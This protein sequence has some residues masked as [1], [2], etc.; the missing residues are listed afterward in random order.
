MK[1]SKRLIA[2]DHAL[3]EAKA[4]VREVGGWN[5]GPRVELYQGADTLPGNHYAWCQSFQN[6]MWR[7]ATG[8]KIVGPMIVG[9]EMLAEGTASVGQAVAWARSKGYVVTRP[10]RGDHFAMLLDGDSW[11]DHTG[12]VVR[13]VSLGPLGYLCNTVEGNTGSGSVDEGDGVYLRTRFLSKSRTIFYRVPG[14]VDVITRTPATV[15]RR[16][17]GYWSWLQWRLGEGLW[18]GW[19]PRNANVRPDVPKRISPKWFTALA[20]YLARRK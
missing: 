1:R 18:K 14:E 20:A 12:Q 9:G 4:N 6:A 8:G 15:L 13:V 16:K 2:L 17:V 3:A 10:Y 19:G 7:L 5:A 11:A